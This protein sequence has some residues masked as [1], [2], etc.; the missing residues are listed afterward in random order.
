MPASPKAPEWRHEPHVA[1]II[2]CGYGTDPA[3]AFANGARALVAAMTPLDGIARRRTVRVSCEA[4]DLEMLFYDWLNAVIYEM[5]A[6]GMVFGDFEVRIEDGRLDASMTGET[7]DPERHAPA[8]EPKGATLSELSVR[9][10]DDGRWAA[11]CVVD[12]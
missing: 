5:A 9:R 1:D 8:V 4:P 7:A 10:L 12:V 6:R 3:Q 11:R 2:V